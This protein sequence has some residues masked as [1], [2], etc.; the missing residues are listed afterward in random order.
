MNESCSHC[1]SMTI[2]VL[3]LRLRTLQRGE[4][5]LEIPRSSSSS[6]SLQKKATSAN[7]IGSLRVTVRNNPP[8]ERPPQ[9]SHSSASLPL[10]PQGERAGPSRVVP[11]VS[12]GAPPEDQM[13]I[14]A[15]E[16]DRSFSGDDDPAALPPS[17]TVVLSEPDPDMTLMLARAAEKVG[18]VWNPPPCP[19]P[20]RL[21]DWFLG[22][23][24][25]GFQRPAPVPFFPEVHEEVT[26]SWTAPL[27]A[28][29]R[30]TPSSSLTTLDG[31]AVKGYEGI[32][33]VERSVAMQLCPKTASTWRGNPS[34]PS[35]AC[36][37]SSSLTGKAYIACGEAA[38]SLHAMA[39]LQVH[40]AQ[41]LCDMQEGGTGPG[42]LQ[43]LRTATD[44][45]LRATKVTARSL[46]RAMSTL[47]V[48]ERHLWLTLADM[49][50]SDKS[51][52]LNS[53]ISQGGLFGDAV[54]SYAQQFSA[55]QKQSEVIK[56]IMPRRQA[57]AA[58]SPVVPPPA[59][60]RRGRPPA[61]TSAPAQPKQQPAKQQ[62]AGRKRGAQPARGSSK[63]PSK[64]RGKRP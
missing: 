15:S 64:R 50:E 26:R 63:P 24:R 22:A 17:G 21:D 47:V 31:G 34:L 36:R 11:V 1:G 32:P 9:A 60:R 57:V 20:S 62:G 52:L 30:S 35:R 2:A 16:G 54:E 27:A 13:S 8:G 4:V 6:G 61:A 58:P 14:A 23:A 33:P 19:E 46:G 51:G 5:P 59:A 28:R 48:Q 56:H 39:L 12:F 10:E 29:H 38:S 55:A 53:P 44:L 40:Q 37:F 41:A 25:V 43:E 7:P 42:A 45:A 18:L 3:R 49:R